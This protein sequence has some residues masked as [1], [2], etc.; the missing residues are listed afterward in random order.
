M[1]TSHAS[2]HWHVA[3]GA[4]PQPQHVHVNV[5]VVGQ[6]SLLALHTGVT[7]TAVVLLTAALMDLDLLLLSKPVDGDPRAAAVQSRWSC[8]CR[9]G[10]GLTPSQA[11]GPCLVPQTVEALPGAR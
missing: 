5:A 3:V 7:Q 6:G 1:P 9:S 11:P 10:E 2:W 4:S 8:A